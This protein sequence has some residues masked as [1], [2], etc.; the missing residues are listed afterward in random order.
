M[1]IIGVDSCGCRGLEV[2]HLPSPGWTSRKA[3]G[4]IQPESEGLRIR[5]Q[6]CKSGLSLTAH[7]PGAPVSKSE[8]RCLSSVE[9]KIH[10]FSAFCSV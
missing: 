5:A 1:F 4:V 7:K 3:C 6:E 2:S 10:S 9:S 8:D